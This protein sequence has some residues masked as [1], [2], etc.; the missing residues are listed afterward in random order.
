MSAR[1]TVFVYPFDAQLTGEWLYQNLTAGDHDYHFRGELELLQRFRE[2]PQASPPPAACCTHARR[3]TSPPPPPPS[4]SPPLPTVRRRPRRPTCSSY[5]GS[6][7]R[8][9]RG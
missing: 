9:L 2:H 5:H 1:P 3:H 7:C 6:P 4:S 8:P